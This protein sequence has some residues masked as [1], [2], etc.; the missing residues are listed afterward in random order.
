MLR[1]LLSVSMVNGLLEDVVLELI[2]VLRTEGALRTMIRAVLS[3][4]IIAF[5]PPQWSSL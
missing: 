3:M 2:A 5:N 1:L 4:T